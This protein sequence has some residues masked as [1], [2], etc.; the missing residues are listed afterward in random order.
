MDLSPR[1]G[2]HQ[3]V[4]ASSGENPELAGKAGDPSS[5]GAVRRDGPASP[6]ASRHFTS[7]KGDASHTGGRTS[8]LVPEPADLDAHGN[9]HAVSP[10]RS[11]TVQGT[12]QVIEGRPPDEEAPQSPSAAT[13][14]TS[15]SG[16]L[17]D[18]SGSGAHSYRHYRVG[19]DI[20]LRLEYISPEDTRVTTCTQMNTCMSRLDYGTFLWSS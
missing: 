9:E 1:S 8:P 11:V 18:L 20:V 6:A 15:D 10:R 13:D 12:A 2:T 19:K 3:L 14:S 16:G 5:E 4:L 7:E 17:A